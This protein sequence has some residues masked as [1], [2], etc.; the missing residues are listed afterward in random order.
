MKKDNIDAVAVVEKDRIANKWN[1]VISPIEIHDY[2]KVD[3]CSFKTMKR[4][5]EVGNKIAK[6]MGWKNVQWEKI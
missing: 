6:I 5:I 3:V 4:A 2:S 1:I